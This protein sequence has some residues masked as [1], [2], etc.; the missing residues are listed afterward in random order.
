MRTFAGLLL[1]ALAATLALGCGEDAERDEGGEITDAGEESVFDLKVG[2]CF[3]TPGDP[4]DGE[5]E[6]VASVDAIPC[7]EPHDNEVYHEYRFA[8]SLV[9][10]YPGEEAVVMEAAEGCFAEFEGF[11]GLSY[12]ESELELNAIL[13]TET[14]WKDGDRIALCYV[15]ALDFSKLTGTM[16]GSER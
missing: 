15:F 14:S 4:Q 16:E 9:E 1:A 12:E 6:E 10:P 13:P 11:V 2:D 8:G 7:G 3:N 5:D